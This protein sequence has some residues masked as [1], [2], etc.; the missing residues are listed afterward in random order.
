MVK[1]KYVCFECRTSKQV[2][3]PDLKSALRKII[4]YPPVK[5]TV[6]KREMKEITKDLKIPNS[7]DEKEWKK[8][9]ILYEHGY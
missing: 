8:V 9:Q 4:H 7:K 5:C 3:F 6:C 1:E 2:Y